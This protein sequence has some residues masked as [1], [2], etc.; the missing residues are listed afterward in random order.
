MNAHNAQGKWARMSLAASHWNLRCGSEMGQRGRLRWIAGFSARARLLM[1]VCSFSW[2]VVGGLQGTANAAESSSNAPSKWPTMVELRQKWEHTSPESLRAAAEHGD[3][4]AAHYLGYCYSTG[5][6]FARD[7]NEAISWY[8]RASAAGYLPSKDHLAKLYLRGEIVP[9]DPTRAFG[10]FLEA[11]EG[12]LAQAQANVGFCYL[13]GT[14]VAPDPQ[15]AFKWFRLAAVQDHTVAIVNVG[16][17]YRFGNGVGRDIQEAIR[18]FKLAS[19]RGDS[20]GTVNLGCVYGYEPDAP[21]DQVKA[22]SLYL[23]AAGLGNAYAMYELYLTYWNGKGTGTDREEA[24]KWLVKGAES[25]DPDAQRTLGFRY[26]NPT[27]QEPVNIA[28]AVRWYKL[29]AAQGEPGGQYY[30]G[31]CLLEGA[32]VEWNDEE[33]LLLIRK[34]AAREHGRAMVKL[35][36]LYARGIGAPRNPQEAPVELLRRAGGAGSKDACEELVFRYSYGLGA[37]YDLVTAAEWYCRGAL[38]G[39]WRYTIEDKLAP[40]P[41]PHALA[42]FRSSTE[43]YWLSACRPN[44]ESERLM[45]VLSLYVKAARDSDSRSPMELAERYLAGID[46]APDPLN[47][48]VWLSIAGERGAAGAS[49][50][51]AG[52]EKEMNAEQ[53]KKAKEKLQAMRSHLQQVAAQLRGASGQGGSR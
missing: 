46:S 13:D 29:A 5:E 1:V 45:P 51:L 35:A 44:D 10:Y 38:A 30:L 25:G 14:G 2:L 53:S 23:K 39:D 31:L 26:Q 12:G 28:E 3:A 7:A 36:E 37:P 6:R 16:R 17:A 27:N 15:V 19:D 50:K 42:S 32:G 22:L 49:A 24:M 4:T 21:M 8:Q 41:Q 43:R 11:A 47:A 48:W 20:L 52:A 18:W 40:G 33:A 34:A 9:A